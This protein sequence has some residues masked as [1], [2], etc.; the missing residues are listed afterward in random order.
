MAI[1][2]WPYRK[3]INF[4]IGQLQCAHRPWSVVYKVD[5]FVMG[6]LSSFCITQYKSHFYSITETQSYNIWSMK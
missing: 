2:Y 3:P 6:T 5:Q 4:K 1:A